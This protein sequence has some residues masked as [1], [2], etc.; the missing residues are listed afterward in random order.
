MIK[1]NLRP[2]GPHCAPTTLVEIE[3]TH[4]MAGG[5]VYP[6]AVIDEICDEAHGAGLKVHIDGARIFNAVAASGVAPSVMTAKAD[7]VNFCLSKGLGAPVGS[8]LV[9]TAEAIAR[10]RLLRKRL[11]GGMRQAGI[12]AAAGLIALEEM[13]KRL[14][15]DHSNAAYLARELA[16]M[17][18]VCLDPAKVVTN[19]V[20]FDI[21]ATGLEVREFS[22]RLKARGVLMNGIGG[23]LVR[24][25]THYDADR[26]ACSRAIAVVREVVGC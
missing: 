20:I 1:R 12:L 13:P 18:G 3:N 26:E 23:T 17:K 14:G 15:E 2:N 7:S 21:A 6:Q 8:L 9:G 5:T 22:A 19:I 4:N 11:G 24:A 16:S 10:G 25:V